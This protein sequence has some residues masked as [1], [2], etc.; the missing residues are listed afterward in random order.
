MV[1]M[2]VVMVMAMPVRQ[3]D[4]VV[5]AVVMVM[6]M[7][8]VMVILRDLFSALRLCLVARLVGAQRDSRH[9]NP[10]RLILGEQLGGRSAPRLILEINIRERLSVLIAQDKR[11]G[12]AGGTKLFNPFSHIL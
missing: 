11:R 8:V 5:I 9:S 1:M 3:R 10:P 4:N 2:V 12:V 6:M 7:M